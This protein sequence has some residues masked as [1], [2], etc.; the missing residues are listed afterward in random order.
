MALS[1]PCQR[2]NAWQGALPGSPGLS[3]GLELPDGCW[4]SLCPEPREFVTAT[5]LK[6]PLVTHIHLLPLLELQFIAQAEADNK[7][8]GS[9]CS[10]NQHH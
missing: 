9:V 4:N 2:F 10:I 7:P 8:A 1:A 3:R 6:M 5:A